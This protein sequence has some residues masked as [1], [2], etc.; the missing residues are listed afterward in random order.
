MKYTPRGT[1]IATFTIA[2]TERWKNSAGQPLEHTEWFNIKAF[3]SIMSAGCPSLLLL[4]SYA[5][6][7]AALIGNASAE[8]FQEDELDPRR[9]R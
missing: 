6:V 1:A 9:F 7:V 3:P 2:C 8:K 4:T 5:L